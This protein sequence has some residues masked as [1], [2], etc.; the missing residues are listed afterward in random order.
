M[1][2]SDTFNR[3]GWPDPRLWTC[4]DASNGNAHYGHT[5]PNARHLY[6]ADAVSVDGTDALTITA[7][8]TKPEEWR[9]GF[10][11]S[12]GGDL[13]IPL[14]GKIS[15][16]ATLPVARGIWPAIWC[17]AKAG[18]ATR[19]EMDLCE[20]F[21]AGTDTCSQH[22]HFPSTTGRS[23]F[24]EGHKL[25]LGPHTYWAKVRADGTG[26]KFTLG[27][28]TIT[29]GT[30]RHPNRAAIEK[31]TNLL[32]FWDVRLNMAASDG[33]YTGTQDNTTSPQ[34]MRVDWV[35]WSA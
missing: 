8:R 18:G 22:L 15:V 21:A 30:Y 13:K 28:D 2:S 20:V 34:V 11:T 26:I 16:E 12:R 35:T 14:Y 7:T 6:S 31:G 23:V 9:S 24:G 32:D 17:C 5:D 19:A 29:S 33:K 1:A 3:K 27:V 10:V 25:A 4:Y